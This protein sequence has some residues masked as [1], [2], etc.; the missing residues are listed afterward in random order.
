MPNLEPTTR[1]FVVS[2]VGLAQFTPADY[3]TQVLD[4]AMHADTLAALTEAALAAEPNPSD[5]VRALAALT[6]A[7]E[8][9]AAATLRAQAA[10]LVQGLV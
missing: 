3:R 6:I 5:E 9:E 8:R 1:V 4:D 2:P 7:E 10:Q